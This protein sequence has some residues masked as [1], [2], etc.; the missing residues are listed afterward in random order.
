[1]SASQGGD[2]ITQMLST[3]EAIT[4]DRLLLATGRK[5]NLDGLGIDTIG[6]DS[7]WRAGLVTSSPWRL[8]G[9]WR[10]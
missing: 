3:G 8:A 10:L 5:A 7:G 2:G 1:M 9:Y 6:L 4:A